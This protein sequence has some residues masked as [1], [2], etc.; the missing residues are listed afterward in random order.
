[1][2]MGSLQKAAPSIIRE[3]EQP[4]LHIPRPELDLLARLQSLEAQIPTTTG[5]H[6]LR[7]EAQRDMLLKLVEDHEQYR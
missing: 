5:E 1:M 7:L 2:A 4:Q 6:R 3:R